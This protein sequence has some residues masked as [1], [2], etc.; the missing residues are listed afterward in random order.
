MGMREHRSHSRHRESCLSNSRVGEVLRGLYS[1]W[2][3]DFLFADCDYPPC[4]CQS[5]FPRPTDPH[6][7]LLDATCRG[8]SL[9]AEVFSWT[10]S[11]RGLARPEAPC[12]HRQHPSA[13]E[14]P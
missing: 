13:E 12:C 6:F 9:T 7:L 5:S 11:R 14:V 3:S 2:C 4:W 1:T 10:N 8:A